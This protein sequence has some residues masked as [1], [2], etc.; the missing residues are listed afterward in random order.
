MKRALLPA[1][2]ASLFAVNGAFAGDR[3]LL[4]GPTG[5]VDQKPNSSA[6][7][8][9]VSKKPAKADVKDDAP[10]ST[11]GVKKSAA[12]VEQMPVASVAASVSAK[13]EK[14]PA[15]VARTEVAPEKVVVAASAAA[16]VAVAPAAST[17]AKVAIAEPAPAKV[18]AKVA[19]TAS[20]PVKAAAVVAPVVVAAAAKT[21]AA[22]ASA[23]QKAEA[24]A[25]Q[26]V[27]APAPVKAGGKTDVASD[28][29]HDSSLIGS[30]LVP[31]VAIAFKPG[32][33]PL[34]QRKVLA[35][36]LKQSIVM[37]FFAS[38]A[39]SWTIGYLGNILPLANHLSSS[40]GVLT[41]LLPERRLSTFATAVMQNRYPAIFINSA[42]AS[43]ALDA[44]YVPLAVA[45]E[46]QKAVFLVNA[47][48][49]YKTQ[50]DIKGARIAY[51]GDTHA[52]YVGFA[53]LA[54]LGINGKA[55]RLN[56]MGIAG[57]E[58]AMRTL[59]SDSSDV[60]IARSADAVRIAPNS[61]IK[62]R[63]IHTELGEPVTGLWVRKDLA[64]S[65]YARRLK[66]SLLQVDAQGVGSG[67]I[68][69]AGFQ[70]GFGV[71]GKFV[72]PDAQYTQNV[73]ERW[74]MTRESYPQVYHYGKFDESKAE[75]GGEELS[76]MTNKFVKSDDLLRKREDFVKTFKSKMSVGFFPSGYGDRSLASFLGHFL[77]LSNHLS[78]NSGTLINFLP[79]RDVGAYAKH[80][81]EQRYPAIFINAAL[82]E[83]ADKAGYVPVAVGQESLS[84]AF[85]VKAT[86]QIQKVEDLR[87][88][89]IAFT[90]NGQASLLGLAELAKRGINGKDNHLI[91]V[92]AGGYRASLDLLSHDSVNV[93]LVRHI[94]AEKLMSET[95][96]MFRII[97]MG[98][99]ALTAP[100]SGFWIRKDIAGTEVA[101]K[102][103][104]AL[105]QVSPSAIGSAKEAAIAFEKGFGVK[106]VFVKPES[107][108]L[109]S[110][111]EKWNILRKGYKNFLPN[112]SD[113]MFKNSDAA[114]R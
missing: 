72:E 14:K 38:D 88:M 27:P 97:D 94:D 66:A 9:R 50:S 102:L 1:L 104:A 87:D 99:D 59:L 11:A 20:A 103:E 92:H 3:E 96:G 85:V 106:G 60:V 40:T 6:P 35:R 84:G 114:K 86:S 39:D 77:P 81:A 21:E 105:L 75:S 4:F 26:T 41:T 91:D 37:G 71:A 90:S 83:T 45:Q 36:D 16:K 46:N 48:S 56:D 33:A 23:P 110:V 17:L 109:E 12:P 54:K 64:N 34:D 57:F 74:E 73:R 89:K 69:G 113:D 63:I 10:T 70:N 78:T 100:A 7:K 107:N 93:A 22:Q 79:E 13:G 47:E 8:A 111:V 53:S 101:R 32:E 5:V 55:N 52:A 19:V 15:V 82:A 51:A 31:H 112:V 29:S 108:Y 43:V 76:I 65:D 98:D 80:I 62:L 68:A 18:P 2:I 28:S 49:P 30:T 58:G 44:G 42:L 95:D 67:K 25:E 61:R 24:S